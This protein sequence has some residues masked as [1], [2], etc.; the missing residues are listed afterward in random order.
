MAGQHRDSPWPG[1][2]VAGP[3][4][5][6][7]VQRQPSPTRIGNWSTTAAASEWTR[8]SPHPRCAG[9]W[10]ICRRACPIDD[11]RLGTVDSWLI[12][13]LTGG[14]EH[15]C[16]AGN[17]SRTLLYDIAELLGVRT[18]ELF[19]VPGTALP[20][21]VAS[22]RGF[23]ETSGVPLV[24]DGTPV[25]AVMADSHAA[26]FGHGCTEVGQAKATYGTGSSV[27]SPVAEP[28]TSE[29][30]VPTTLAW[31]VDNSATYAL[32]GNILYSGATLAWAADLLT[33]GR[34]GDVI[35][36]AETVD[37][38]GGVTLV[39]AFSGFGSPHWDATPMR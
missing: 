35:T 28:S 34:V 9:Y 14:M 19:G 20:A 38:S 1:D 25:L 22:D 11:V 37:D 29:E 6:D 15:L 17:A 30:R 36:L 31:V 13:R 27:M 33:D 26:L 16:E 8:C 5:D 23:G 2:R 10:T 18:L 21:A 3:P 12:W 7:L 39:P 4:Y 32:E 24:P